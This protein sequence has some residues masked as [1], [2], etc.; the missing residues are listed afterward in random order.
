MATVKEKLGSLDILQQEGEE[1]I[2][3]GSKINIVNP[4]SEA[5]NFGGKYLMVDGKQKIDF[6]RLDYLGLGSNQLIRKLMIESIKTCDI[7]CPASQVVMKSKPTI[8]LERT[9]AELHNMEESIVFTSGYA[10]NEN[11]MLALGSRMNSRHLLTY[12]H[13]TGMGQS[14]RNIKT[15]FFV[16]GDS[17]FSLQFGISLAKLQGK[18]KC[19]VYKF[20]NLDHGI[21][22]D[23]L[24]DSEKF[25]TAVRVI[26]SDTLCSSSGKIVD[27]KGLCELAEKYDCLLFLDEAHAVGV[28]GP[29]GKGVTGSVDGID[30]YRDRLM[31]MGTLTK[32]FCQ[33]GGYVA[34]PSRSLSW[35][36]RICCPQY[37]FS[38][39]VP[40]WMAQTLVKMIKLVSGQFGENERYKLQEVAEYMRIQLRS[41]DFN[42]LNSDSH[43]IP[44]AIGDELLAANVKAF[45]EEEGFVTSLFEHPAV[46]KGEALVR[47]SL[48]S[49][50]TKDEV[51][52]VVKSL[53]LARNMFNF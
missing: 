12:F 45:L 24:E 23:Q 6:T 22:S 10:T 2:L 7:S 26:V 9:L 34:F 32:A 49:D 21:L 8:E 35:Y 11:M 33:L 51:D 48:C 39:P 15:I 41:R 38:A 42:I 1:F 5:D 13:D 31:I 53:I 40:P 28:L 52:S 43:I 36:L 27:I 14:T 47:F 44:I 3:E 19:F 25:G 37:I 17:H 29:Q 50:I 4:Q 18:D 46:R 20:P 30:R 16:D